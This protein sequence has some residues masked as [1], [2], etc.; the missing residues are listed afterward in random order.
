MKIFFI[1]LLS[2]LSVAPRAYAQEKR[3]EP[4]AASGVQNRCGW[5]DNPTPANWDLTDKDGTWSIGVQGG[6]QAEGELPEF[7]QNSKF[8]KKTNGNYGYGCACL[9]VKVDAKEKTVL[10]IQGGN[11][12]PLSKCRADKNLKSQGR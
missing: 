3:L 8:W 1:I 6:P 10:A 5:V 7:P 11:P 4:H 12:L 9:Q 2:I